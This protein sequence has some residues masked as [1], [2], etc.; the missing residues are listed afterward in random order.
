MSRG[1]VA[2]VS[3]IKWVSIEGYHADVPTMRGPVLRSQLFRKRLIQSPALILLA[4]ACFDAKAD[5][6]SVAASQPAEQSR[7]DR[8]SLSIDDIGQKPVIPTTKDRS[9]A[10]PSEAARRQIR[11]A[12]NRMSDKAWSSAADTLDRLLESEPDCVEA[13]LL[14]ARVAMQLGRNQTAADH[15]HEALALDPHAMTAHRLL[16]EI[17]LQEGRPDSAIAEFRAALASNEARADGPDTILSQLSL[18]LVLKREGYYRAAADALDTFKAAVEKPTSD[19]NAHAEVAEAIALYRDRLDSLIGECRIAS[20]GFDKAIPTLRAIL[21]ANP[22]NAAARRDLILAL[23]RSG[24]GEEALSLARAAA[25]EATCT[26]ASLSELKKVCEWVGANCDLGDQL[27]QLLDSPLKTEPLLNI[28]AAAEAGGATAIAETALDK[29]IAQEPRNPVAWA[30]RARLRVAAAAPKLLDALIPATEASDDSIPTVDACIREVVASGRGRALLDEAKSRRLAKPSVGAAYVVARVQLELGQLDEAA[31]E[32]EKLT[33]KEKASTAGLLGLVAVRTEQSRWTD[34][35]SAAESAVEEHPSATLYLMLARAYAAMDEFDKAEA[36]YL[37][38]FSLARKDSTPLRELAE[39]LERRGEPKRCEEIYRRIVNDVNPRDSVAREALVRLYLISDNIK[40]AKKY[41][42]DFA[43]LDQ[44]GPMVDCCAAL[45]EFA[46]G[47]NGDGLTRLEAYRKA[48]RAVAEK[49]PKHVACRFDLAM[50]YSQLG[51]YAEAAKWTNEALQNDA[52]DLRSLELNAQLQTRLLDFDGSV[53]T[54]KTLLKRR[55]RS[56]AWLE[57]LVEAHLTRADFDAGVEVLR[58]LLKRE[59]LA[60]RHERYT[61]LLMAALAAGD[62]QDEALALAKERLEAQPK[63]ISRRGRYVFELGRAGRHDEAIA[64]VRGWLE[65]EPSDSTL[66]NLLIGRLDDAKRYTEAEAQMLT[67]LEA[68]P[69][70]YTLNFSL[71]FMHWRQRDWAGAIEICEAAAETPAQ[72]DAFR[73][74]IAQT[75]MQAEQYDQAIQILESL[76][77][78]KTDTELES[79]NVDVILAMMQA[80]R[81]AD[82]EKTALRIVSPHIDRRAAGRTHDLQLILRFRGLLSNIYQGM[83]RMEDAY[84]Q[85]VEIRKINPNDPEANNNLAYTWSEGGAELELAEKYVR[86]ALAEEPRNAA[87]LDTLGWVLYKRGQFAD[88]ARWLRLAMK[89]HDERDPVMIN[90]LGDALARSGDV[91]SAKPLWK[92]AFELVSQEKDENR[93]HERRILRKTLE[94]KVAAMRDDKPVPTAPLGGEPHP[95]ANTNAKPV[96]QDDSE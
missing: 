88:A 5:D 27:T 51:E 72:Q 70:D 23:A 17:A 95:G 67:W 57:Q 18:G 11:I 59:D 44:S 46:T 21:D 49:Y 68:T 4:F 55:P 83:G 14:A 25:I 92:S 89:Q 94:A 61:R 87:Y 31:N 81:F 65:Q 78:G 1:E 12:T 38:S 62:H 39:L 84:E 93:T 56:A 58:E 80:E 2:A 32:F 20:G 82:A 19:M 13:R 73:R 47:R 60:T 29:I 41:F 16:G 76:A 86:A 64:A 69:D 45:M 71:V 90:H 53:E 85:L 77:V 24:Q 96:S 36:A 9:P 28:A 48:L 79:P 52:S 7:A 35:I 43:R 66:R 30:A 10:K 91:D 33:S 34:A 6:A 3:A 15:L 74:L 63:D 22:G 8:A 40:A 42:D 26:P 54:W 75:H 37:E 50:T